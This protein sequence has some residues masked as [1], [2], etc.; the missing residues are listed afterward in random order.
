MGMRRLK[1]IDILLIVNF[2]L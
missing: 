2:C 1:Y